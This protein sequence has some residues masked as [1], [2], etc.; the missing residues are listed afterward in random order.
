[1]ECLDKP[2]SLPES[3]ILIVKR[4]VV[5]PCSVHLLVRNQGANNALG[6]SYKILHSS[7]TAPHPSCAALS[8]A[9]KL[10]GH[11]RNIDFPIVQIPR[12]VPGHRL[13]VK[14]L[15]ITQ[16]IESVSIH[17]FIIGILP[18]GICHRFHCMRSSTCAIE[19]S[20]LKAH[21]LRTGVT[22]LAITQ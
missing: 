17:S 20:L 12:P 7:F 5:Y 16:P 15:T 14:R 9:F 11:W 3:G 8:C 18:S 13:L 6:I 2:K 4:F 21:A 19:I 1:M 10:F 22:N